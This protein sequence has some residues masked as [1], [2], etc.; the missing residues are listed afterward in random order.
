MSALTEPALVT[1]EATSPARIAVSW[2][3]A[4]AELPRLVRHPTFLL[5]LAIAALTIVTTGTEPGDPV[6]DQ[7]TWS[8]FILPTPLAVAFA[9]LGSRS[10][11]NETREIEDATGGGQAVVQSSATMLVLVP[12]ATVVAVGI[13]GGAF[14]EVLGANK[15]SMFSGGVAGE[16]M[17]VL[18]QSAVMAAAVCAFALA[19]GSWLPHWITAMLILFVIWQGADTSFHPVAW[20]SSEPIP[21]L[22]WH[23]AYGSGVALLASTAA[24]LKHRRDAVTALVGVTGLA[25]AIAGGI[26][27]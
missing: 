4:R 12:A 13:L 16:S 14:A 22:A 26:L 15:A 21:A 2:S 18:A 8:L 19:A 24:L 7:L 9:L 1:R 20:D 10:T 11:R 25:L 5:S 17:L 6:I 27:Q 3:L 23:L